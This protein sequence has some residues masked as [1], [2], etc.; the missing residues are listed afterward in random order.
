MILDNKEC[1]LILAGS[2]VVGAIY[3]SRMLSPSVYKGVTQCS[4]RHG[5]QTEDVSARVGTI[6]SEGEEITY[7]IDDGFNQ[8]LSA[9]FETQFKGNLPGGGHNTE[10]T[11][12]AMKAVR[13]QYN[14]VPTHAKNLGPQI[15]IP[16]R[17]GNENVKKRQGP[18]PDMFNYPEAAELE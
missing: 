18:S 7:G 12:N 10:K 13:A 2:V 6:E 11:K 16:G 14:P 3:I 15:L 9:D 17:P 8:E 4:A 1:N 5:K